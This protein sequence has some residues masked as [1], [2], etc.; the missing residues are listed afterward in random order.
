MINHNIIIK[1]KD[2]EDKLDIAYKQWAAAEKE[3]G[4]YKA[5]LGEDYK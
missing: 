3:L 5:S 4:H 2:L 1:I